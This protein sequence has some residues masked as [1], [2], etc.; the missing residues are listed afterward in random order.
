MSIDS[1]VLFLPYQR[2]TR[3]GLQVP[4]PFPI[5][6]RTTSTALCLRQLRLTTIAQKKPFAAKPRSLSPIHYSHFLQNHKKKKFVTIMGMKGAPA[7]LSDDDVVLKSPNDR[8]LY[9]L[10]HLPNGLRALLV[11]DPE[12][13]PE[14][15]P[16]HVS[17]EDEVEEEDDDDEE[18]DEDEEEE[19]E[20][21]DDDDDDEEEEEGNEMDG[22]K[23]G[24]AAAQSKKAAAAMCVGMGSFSDPY[25]AQGLAHFLEHMLFM[26]SDE[27]PDENEYDSYLSKHGGSSNAYTE[28]EYTCYHFEVK[29]EFLKGA[30]KRFSQFFISPLVKM[31]AMEREVL[32]VDSEF[33]QVLQSDACRLQQLQCHTAAHNHPLNRFFWG[34]KKSLVDAMEK[35]INLREQIL[36]LYKEYY[37]GGLMKLVVIGGESLDVLESWVVELFGAV[38]KGQ[39]NPVFTVEGP[40]WKSGK[41]YRLEAVKDVH[42]LDLSWT[43]PCLH[44]EYLKKPEDYLAHLLGHEGRGSLLSFLK[45]RGWATS[46]SAGVGEEGIYRSSIAYVFVMSIHLTDS[47]VEKIFDIIGFV[48][49]YLK[50]LSQDS[51]QEWIFKELQNI[52]NMD[53]RFAE[54]QP[55]DDYAAELAENMHFY[56]PE[57][58]IYGDYVFKTWDKQLLKQVLGFFIP[59]NMR[60]DV[61]S[62]SFLKSEDFQYEPWFGS[63]YVEEDI[64]QSFMELWRN[65]PEIDVSLHLPSKNEFIPSDFSIRASDTCVDDFAN[66]TSPRCIIDE[67]LIKL[68][69]KPDST[70]KVPRANTYFRI[71]MKGG[72]AD[73]KSCVLSELFIHLLKDELNEITYQ[74]SIAKLET[75]VTYVGDMLELKVYGF[76]EKLPVLLSKFFS[77]SK[78]FVP[79]DDRFKVIKEDMKRALKNTNMKP[80]SHSTYLR[81]QVLCESFYDADEK[82]CYLND[83]FLDDLK[84]FIPGL[85]SQIYVEG[86]CHGN[87]SKEE[88]INISKIFKMSFPVNPLPIELRHA[89]RVICL[90][91]SANLVRDVNVKNKSEKN[92]V[93]ELYFQIDQDFGLGSIKLKALIDLFDEIV[94]EPFFNQLRTKEQLGYVVECSPRVT[95]R[96]F[97]FCF[98]VQSSEYNPVYL[99]GRIENF[100][101]GLEELLDGLDGDSFENYK[102]GLV[103]KLLEKDP[104]L[105][106]ESNRLWNQIVEKRYIFDLSKKEAEELKNISKHDIVEWYKTYLKPSS[107]KCRQ[108]LIRLWGCNTD[109]KEAEALPKSVLAITDPAAFKMQSKFYPSFC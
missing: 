44:Q 27:F 13:Y 91:S 8:R 36:K 66:S 70:F 64:G 83:L 82:L 26:G 47:G 17:N 89:E 18:E 39:A 32:A 31:E 23:G 97:G 2:R 78:S 40:I 65:P 100:L 62:K 49:Q 16:K 33:N 3:V 101:N 7:T 43:L 92:S 46:L 56:P 68:W 29:R 95:Y 48:Y 90:P 25:E 67:A 35:G 76:N 52:G 86:L 24:A 84:A 11:H 99:Q 93:V 69:Y 51:P 104:S 87:L 109:L 34:N 80:L 37:H 88:A 1:R 5:K 14:G 105:T 60:V 57:H 58:V 12:I 22:V 53:F 45:S 81:L 61:V 107:P 38:K 79:T 15:P 71:T 4:H 74:A 54:E 9:R 50:L 98:C 28:T 21:E 75:S 41:V 73:V 10:I 106:Y 94:E 108:L 20:D 77:V 63:R 59:E 42:I 55:P 102:S 6:T 30:L 85:L 72:Y 19:E 96:V 103:A